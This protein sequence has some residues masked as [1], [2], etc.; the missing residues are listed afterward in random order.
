VRKLRILTSGLAR[1]WPIVSGLKIALSPPVTGGHVKV[2]R[3]R[4]KLERS[5]THGQSH[6]G[7]R[8]NWWSGT[9]TDGRI[10]GRM[11]C[12]RSW[13]LV[14]AVGRRRVLFNGGLRYRL[15]T[16][17]ERRWPELPTLLGRDGHVK[18]WT[19]PDAAATA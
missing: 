5:A 7:S 2:E 15:T 11:F 19:R 10:V 9:S 13:L 3:G 1:G 12:K 14:G 4:G 6:A 17:N 16:M 8:T 18:C